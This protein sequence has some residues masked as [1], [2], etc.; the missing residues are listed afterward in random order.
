VAVLLAVLLMVSLI[1]QCHFGHVC[2]V[3]EYCYH[4]KKK[5]K[6]KSNT[7]VVKQIHTGTCTHTHNIYTMSMMRPEG[8][9][10]YITIAHGITNTFYFTHP[11]AKFYCHALLL[12]REPKIVIL[13]F[14]IKITVILGFNITRSTKVPF[15][16][17]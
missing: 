7:I 16:T 14:G 15:L 2:R 8:K 4:T 12:Y 11:I 13:N 3:H 1:L 5:F 6:S 9:C 10:I 17:K